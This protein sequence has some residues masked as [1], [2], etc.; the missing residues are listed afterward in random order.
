[1]T[2]RFA[3]FETAETDERVAD[4]R[5]WS[6]DDSPIGSGEKR[7]SFDWRPQDGRCD[8][9]AVALQGHSQ[10]TNT[11]KL[12]VR[13]GNS[14]AQGRF[15]TSISAVCWTPHSVWAELSRK[16]LKEPPDLKVARSNRAGRTS[17]E[18]HLQAARGWLHLSQN[19]VC[20]PFCALPK[21]QPWREL[22]SRI[23]PRATS[24]EAT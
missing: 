8:T 20:G 17:Q 14:P 13:Q 2:F 9:V 3:R 1:V 21:S 16:G 11:A 15:I 4:Q 24:G 23:P 12:P 6:S 10:D 19:R 18:S 7:C 5:R 22:G